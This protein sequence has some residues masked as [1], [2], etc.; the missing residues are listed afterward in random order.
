VVA[1]QRRNR[2]PPNITTVLAAGRLERRRFPSAGC[3][4]APADS[5][6]RLA[7]TL[8]VAEVPADDWQVLHRELLQAAYAFARAEMKRGAGARCD[9]SNVAA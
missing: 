7:E 6:E 8:L 3:A 1:R 2:H 9:G 4:P 5:L